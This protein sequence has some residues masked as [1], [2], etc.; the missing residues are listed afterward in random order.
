M[1]LSEEQLTHVKQCGML[2]Y[3]IERTIN[4]VDL[5]ASEEA[6]FRRQFQTEGS[7]VAKAYQRGKEQAEYGLDIAL[8]KRAKAGDMKAINELEKRKAYGGR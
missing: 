8:L 7:A 6:D 4:I 1:E 5:K 3:D 2:G